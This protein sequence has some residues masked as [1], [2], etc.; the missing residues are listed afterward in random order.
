MWREETKDCTGT[1]LGDK[2][3]VSDED[4]KDEIR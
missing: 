4:Y 1:I 2:M 3:H